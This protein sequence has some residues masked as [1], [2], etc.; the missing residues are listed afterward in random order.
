MVAHALAALDE[1]EVPHQAIAPAAHAGQATTSEETEHCGMM[2]WPAMAS[3]LDGARI[4]FARENA[5]CEQTQHRST[6]RTS[7]IAVFNRSGVACSQ[8]RSLPSAL[9]DVEF[10]QTLVAHFQK[11]RLTGL[12][13]REIGALHDLVSLE[14]LLAKCIQNIFAV[15]QHDFPLTD[16]DAL[17]ECSL[18]HAELDLT[19]FKIARRERRA[20]HSFDHEPIGEKILLGLQLRWQIGLQSAALPRVPVRDL[21]GYRLR[22][23]ADLLFGG[24]GK[25]PHTLFPLKF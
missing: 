18:D 22:S 12:L 14:R 17:F 6:K 10:Y 5:S 21:K 7:D 25:F 13:I 1:A 15:L 11:Q 8:S 23:L 2:H 3:I 16:P 19:I 24:F 9:V 20:C 4:L